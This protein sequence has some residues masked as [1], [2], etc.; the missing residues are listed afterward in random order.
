MNCI[1]IGLLLV[2]VAAQ[3]VSL[4]E[5]FA[6]AMAGAYAKPSQVGE[7][8]TATSPATLTQLVASRPVY[9]LTI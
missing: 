1:L 3:Y 8:F 9:Y 5:T 4:T 6:T 2:I 7:A